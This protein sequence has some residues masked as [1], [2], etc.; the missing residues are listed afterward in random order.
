M[1]HHAVNVIREIV[2]HTVIPLC[3][4]TPLNKNTNDRAPDGIA[5]VL[6][7]SLW[8]CVVRGGNPYVAE[9]SVTRAVVGDDPSS[10]EPLNLRGADLSDE[11]SVGDRCYVVV[12]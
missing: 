6:C 4:P 10:P 8:G 3:D 12:C 9:P 2:K 11:L 5:L 1:S 7:G